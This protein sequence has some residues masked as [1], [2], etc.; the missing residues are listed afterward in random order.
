MLEG[1][2]KRVVSIACGLLFLP[3]LAVAQTGIIAGVVKDTSGAVMPGVNV[4]AASPALIEKIRAAVTD[5][6]GQYKVVD[7]PPGTYTVTFT[8]VGFNAVKR[9]GVELSA[10]FT[11]NV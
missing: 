6:A 9:E 1:R 8:L 3:A 2:S 4:E 7:L 5:T 11:A 10:G